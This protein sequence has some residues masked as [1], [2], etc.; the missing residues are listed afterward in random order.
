VTEEKVNA[1]AVFVV[2]PKTGTHEADP[3]RMIWMMILAILSKQRVSE[4]N[5]RESCDRIAVTGLS[6]TFLHR[7][8]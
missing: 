5:E 2:C 6:R 4:S 7:A 8:T 3:K 1:G